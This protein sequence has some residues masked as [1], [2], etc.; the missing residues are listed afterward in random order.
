MCVQLHCLN[1]IAT[2]WKY[3]IRPSL[4]LGE[5]L[6]RDVPREIVLRAILGKRA[7]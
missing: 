1:V 5:F 3:E 7:I 4:I 2:F 6:K